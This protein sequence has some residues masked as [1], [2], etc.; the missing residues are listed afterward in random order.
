MRSANDNAKCQLVH[1][2][3]KSWFG[4]GA[5][6]DLLYAVALRL[7][8]LERPDAPVVP[9]RA[10]DPSRPVVDGSR[11]PRALWPTEAFTDAHRRAQAGDPMREAARAIGAPTWPSVAAL[12]FKN[13]DIDVI[14]EML[15]GSARHGRPAARIAVQAGLYNLARHW[16]LI[17]R[18]L[19][20]A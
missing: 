10:S 11:D 4:D 8:S 14:G 12:V 2:H 19:E 3:H 7:R 13:E 6:N 9:L 16:G 17:G 20:A 5:L 18:Q 15:G 1:W